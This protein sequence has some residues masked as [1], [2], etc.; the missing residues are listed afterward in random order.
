M[1]RT[2]PLGW[3]SPLI[4]TFTNNFRTI[5]TDRTAMTDN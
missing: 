3:G 2:F 4:E 5:F 1:K